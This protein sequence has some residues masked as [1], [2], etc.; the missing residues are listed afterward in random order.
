MLTALLFYIIQCSKTQKTHPNTRTYSSNAPKTGNLL[1]RAD[2][3]STHLIWP[4]TRRSLDYE[5][6][7]QTLIGP[8]IKK[9]S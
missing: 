2:K 7:I 1:K 8:K 3:M 5:V 9:E 6:D 4:S